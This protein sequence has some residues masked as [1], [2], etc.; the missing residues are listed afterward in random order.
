M[1]D[2]TVFVKAAEYL[3]KNLFDGACAAVQKFSPTSTTEYRLKTRMS[4]HFSPSKGNHLAA[5]HLAAY[6]WKQDFRGRGENTYL[7]FTRT[8]QRER[9]IMLLLL[10]AMADAGDLR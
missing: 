4:E 8:Q 7:G 9:V 1:K 5:Y 3:D 10:A 6:W 2:S